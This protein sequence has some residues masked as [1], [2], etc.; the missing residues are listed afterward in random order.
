MSEAVE[1]MIRVMVVDDH[2]IV[3]E[4]LTGVLNAAPDMVCV[5]EASNGQDAVGFYARFQ[6][7][8]ILMDLVMPLMDG[9]AATRAIVAA[10]PQTR[11]V[12][13][14]SFVD[15]AQVQAALQAGAVGYLLKD[16]ST[17]DILGTIRAAHSNKTTLAPQAAQALIRANTRPALPS[18]QLK[19]RELEILALM[20]EGLS[21]PE[22]GE[23]LSLSRATIKFYVSSILAKLGVSNRLEAV[24]LAITQGLV[25]KRE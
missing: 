5:G 3:R 6:P 7:D 13:L 1:P 16:A 4:G 21:N 22:M 18:H 9:I 14:T 20:V 15:D 12:I 17:R 2:A 24:K 11:V 8:V 23:R 10:S 25:D 19:E